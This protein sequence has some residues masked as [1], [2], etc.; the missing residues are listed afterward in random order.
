MPLF[1]GSFRMNNEDPKGFA[2]SDHIP[3]LA[4]FEL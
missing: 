1:E 3:V 4:D 2:L